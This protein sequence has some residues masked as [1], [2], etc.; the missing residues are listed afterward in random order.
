MKKR[1]FILLVV[2]G[3]VELMGQQ[4]PPMSQYMYNPYLINPAATGLTDY[5]P[6]AFT[7]RKLWAGISGSPTVQ[8]LTA[9]S[10]IFPTMGAGAKFINYQ[11]GPL[12]KTGAE[13]TYSYH[14]QLNSDLKLALGLSCLLYQFNLKKSELNVEDE[15]DPVFAGTEKMIVPDA[16]FGAYLYA[17]EYY[18]GLSVPQLFNRN[19]DLKSDNVLQEK[20][21]R[22]YYLFGG[23][24]FKAGQDFKINPS[25]M[26]K[27]IEA[28]L[29]QVDINLHARY[30]DIFLAGVSFRSSDAVVLQ[31]GF[32]Y[33]EMLF[34]YSYDITVSGLNAATF[35]SHEI[36]L[37]YSLPGLA[38]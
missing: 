31:V 22:H 25:M 7:Y 35:G 5:L 15:G 34:G 16:S 2:L 14:F 19:I 8:Y 38:R 24:N 1:L 36:Q 20:Q 27:F 26:I 28:G 11:A 6:I 29:Y 17:E 32:N 13:L 4:I 18:V 10:K 37:I 33:K 23:Y 3:S 30:K 9:N 12:R 21:V